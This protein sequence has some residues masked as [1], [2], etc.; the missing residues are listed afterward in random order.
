M[1]TALAYIG[2]LGIDPIASCH[3]C[4]HARLYVVIYELR[5]YRQLPLSEITVEY[6]PFSGHKR[7]DLKML[8]WVGFT[9]SSL[10]RSR[11]SLTR[12][13]KHPK[14]Y[15]LSKTSGSRSVS[16]ST[17]VTHTRRGGGCSGHGSLRPLLMEEGKPV[18]YFHHDEKKKKDFRAMAGKT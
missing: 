13:R 7:I 14:E 3:E 15:M 16:D 4:S 10:V 6:E 5:Y 9:H 11:V 12:S 1:Y 17:L 8:R 2:V 18:C